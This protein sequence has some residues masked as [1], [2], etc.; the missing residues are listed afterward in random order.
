M[1]NKFLHST[2]YILHSI[3]LVSFITALGMPVAYAKEGDDLRV[4]YSESIGAGKKVFHLTGCNWTRAYAPLTCSEETVKDYS[5]QCQDKNG[6]V[7]EGKKIRGCY[8]EPE[9]IIGGYADVNVEQFDKDKCGNDETKWGYKYVPQWLIAEVKDNKIENNYG[10]VAF[11]ELTV[12]KPSGGLIGKVS[13][14]NSNAAAYFSYR[15]NLCATWDLVDDS[16]ETEDEKMKKEVEEILEKHQGVANTFFTIGKELAKSGCNNDNSDKAVPFSVNAADAPPPLVRCSV[17][18]RIT[19]K[20]GTDIFSQYVGALYKWAAGI[21]G[22]I[23]VLIIV[24]SG[25]Q[26]SAS[27]DGG[28]IDEAKH[29]IMQSIIGLVIL[30]LA[31]LILYTINPGF[32]V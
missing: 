27:A 32:F 30:F 4:Y 5:K 2:Y 16:G 14:N 6:K 19:G 24:F 7:I 21:V 1:R 12:D 31:G 10:T 26:I 25:V 15:T 11:S 23:T 17:M 3:L 9:S 13:N 20:S 29:R 18:E 28:Q 8:I 22:I